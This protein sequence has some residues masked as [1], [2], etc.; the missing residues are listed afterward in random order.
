MHLGREITAGCGKTKHTWEF[1]N[2]EGHE[3]EIILMCHYLPILTPE[4]ETQ[5]GKKKDMVISHYPHTGSHN[6]D[7]GKMLTE[8]SNTQTPN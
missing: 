6:R 3:G 5:E 8:I 4:G 7:Q 2:L 1:G